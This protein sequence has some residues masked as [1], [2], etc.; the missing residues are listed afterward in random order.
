MILF[1]IKM[2]LF[3]SLLNTFF[4]FLCLFIL[5][6]FFIEFIKIRKIHLK[7]FTIALDIYF[8]NFFYFLNLIYLFVF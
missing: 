4:F 1:K 6:Y 8:G 5:Y 3:E 2:L 7:F